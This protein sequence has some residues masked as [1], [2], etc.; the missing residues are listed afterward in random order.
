MLQF[1][2]IFKRFSCAPSS[3]VRLACQRHHVRAHTKYD[4]LFT[5]KQGK[6]F[7]LQRVAQV[8]AKYLK[9]EVHEKLQVPLLRTYGCCRSESFFTLSYMQL[10]Q[11]IIFAVIGSIPFYASQPV[12]T[13]KAHLV[14]YDMYAT[15]CVHFYCFVCILLPVALSDFFFVLPGDA[16]SCTFVVFSLYFTSF[17]LHKSAKEQLVAL[18]DWYGAQCIQSYTVVSEVVL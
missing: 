1:F 12:Y 5:R 17:Y 18:L 3:L 7:P 8:F 11:V 13:H 9:N 10:D 15:L 4:T 14:L 2:T 6:A 16:T